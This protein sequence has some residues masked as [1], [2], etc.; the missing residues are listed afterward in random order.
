MDDRATRPTFGTPVSGAGVVLE[1][2]TGRDLR[3]PPGGHL[4]LSTRA[5]GQGSFAFIDI[6]ARR[7]GTC[8]RLTVTAPGFGTYRYTDVY[9]AGETSFSNVF[10]LVE[11]RTE[12]GGG[13]HVRR[14]SVLWR[15]I[16]AAEPS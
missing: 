14:G 6:P 5:D 10:L 4:R 13:P 8:Y 15:C 9:L 12:A 11:P 2:V 3:P 16:D 7:E 1:S